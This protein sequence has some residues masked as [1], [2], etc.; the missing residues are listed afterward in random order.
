MLFERVVSSFLVAAALAAPLAYAV[1]TPESSTSSEVSGYKN[2]AYF[3]NW[4]IYAR[5]YQPQQLP[6]SKLTHVLYAFANIQADGT[7]YLSDSY[8]DREKH[9]PTDSWN[10]VGN[11]VYGC[12]K[13][14]Y[15]L[16][17]KNRKMKTLLSIGGWTYS[18][19]FAAASST[20]AN[21]ARFASTAVQFVKD[22]GLDGLD[23]DWEYPA[24]DG[25]AGNFVLLLAA[26]RSAL[27]SYA[28]QYA[29]GYHLLIT[30]ASP[31]GPANYNIMHKGEMDK[32]LDAWHLMAY[33]YSGSWDTV[34]GHDAN[35]YPSSSNPKSTPYSTTKA[36]TDYIASGVTASKI[37][38]GMP[39]YGRSFQGTSG[40]GQPFSGVGSGSWENGVWDYKALPKAGATEYT[41][42]T[43]GVSWSYDP[44][45]KEFISYDNVATIQQKASYIK[46]TGLG[47]GM[48]W[49]TSSDRTDSKSLISTVAGSFGNLEQSQNLLSY[50][51][52]QYANLIAGMPGE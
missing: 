17:K 39:L 13:Q 36:I 25:E 9:Y 11:N 19:N 12:V 49:E 14:L 18:T 38:L 50:P 3:V 4:A 15:L 6:A 7:V 33:D 34:A 30:I 2:A 26:V 29:P 48:F 24:N 45:T 28:A 35:L 31:A 21:R 44:S 32:Y 47:G 20:A 46:N 10:D 1:P 8:S 16:K 22:W 40:S 23:I 43:L 37:V 51:G 42:A 52:S 5:N 41:D 27:D